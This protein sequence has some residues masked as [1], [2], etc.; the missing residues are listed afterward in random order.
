[1]PLLTIELL[2]HPRVSLAGRPLDVRVRKELALLA[3]LAV[4]Q[5]HRHSRDSL[6]GLFWPDVTEEAARNNLRVVLAGL[7]RLLGAASDA[8]LLAERQH[9]Q[10]LPHSDHT[11]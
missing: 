3:Y 9:V 6:L 10:F 4:E 5:E 2:G 7:R 1:M 11:L 8:L